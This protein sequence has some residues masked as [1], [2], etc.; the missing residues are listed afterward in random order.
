MP[1][2]TPRK[3][4]AG[5]PKLD[6][7]TFVEITSNLFIFCQKCREKSNEM[8]YRSVRDEGSPVFR[9]EAVCIRCSKTL[10]TERKV[11]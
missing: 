4:D 10:P 2:K 3:K 7:W 9:T 11:G 1:V 5:I 8:F 6:G